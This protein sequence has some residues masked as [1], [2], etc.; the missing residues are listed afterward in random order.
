MKK[1]DKELGILTFDYG[2]IKRDKIQFLNQVYDIQYV[3]EAYNSEDDITEKQRESALQFSQKQIDYEQKI[4]AS[5]QYYI[6]KNRCIGNF[7]PKTLLF[8]RNGDLGLLGE[9]DWDIEDGLVI[10]IRPEI[11]IG[12]QNIFL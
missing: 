11:K 5:F 9:C 8:K 2:W 1:N 10:I 6:E 3:F 7:I 4:S 12:P